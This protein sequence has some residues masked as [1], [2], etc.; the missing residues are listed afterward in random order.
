[1]SQ[2]K[3]YI[4]PTPIGNLKDIT[5]RAIEVLNNVNEILAEDTRTSGK[6][7]KHLEINSKL[8]SYHMHN[9]H[10]I[11]NRVIEKLKNGNDLALISDAGTPG[12]SDPGYLL[13]KTAQD[14]LID[15]ECL[16]GATAFVPA[17]VQSGLPCD[18]FT[19][20][21]FLPQKK[22]RLTAIK[23]LSEIEHTVVLYESPYRIEK[24]INQLYE[25]LGDRDFSYSREISK[26]FHET[27]SGT[28]ADACVHIK[29]ATQKGE[30]VVVIGK[31][32]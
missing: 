13:I 8:S 10:S 6:L 30:F 14:M 22:G 26:Q 29:T 19:F 21:G 3:L 11:V 17:L 18:K 32:K 16:P 20:L 23:Q 28:L 24:L 25:E 4:V 2:G 7:L 15:V 5:I 27:Y 1:M 9:E 31:P 12:I